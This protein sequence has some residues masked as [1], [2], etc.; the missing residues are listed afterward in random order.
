MTL[1]GSL[2]KTEP[3]LTSCTGH[4]YCFKSD[5]IALVEQ[6]FKKF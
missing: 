6:L 5:D 3:P 1:V 2:C 4:F